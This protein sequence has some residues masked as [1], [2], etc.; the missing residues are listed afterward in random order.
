MKSNTIQHLVA[1]RA[2]LSPHKEALVEGEQRY[3]YEMFSNQINRIANFLV[4]QGVT[5][6]DRVGILART[7]AAYP[8]VMMAIVKIGAVVSPLS[9]NM[10][11]YELD[12]IIE[13][14][15]LKALLHHQEFS[16]VV[17]GAKAIDQLDFTVTLEREPKFNEQFN[18][19]SAKEPFI[20]YEVTEEDTALM[21]F[22][23]GTTG[24]AKGCMISHGGV[25]KYLESGRTEDLIHVEMH[26]LFVHPFFH[27]SSM[28]SMFHC[29]KS[30]V[31]MVC[32]EETEPARILDVIEK[33]DITLLLALPP[34]LTYLLEELEQNP[35]ENLP[36]KLALSG[37]T[38][39]PESLIRNLEKHGVTVAQGYGSTEAWVISAWA[40]QMGWDKV[41]SVGK[42]ISGVEV[43]VV[44][45][46][47]REAVAT[48][49]IGE[50]LV[51]SPYIFKGYWGNEAATQA[52]LHDGW[53][54]MGDAGK[55]D[56]DGFLYIDGRYKDVIVYGGDN[57]YPDQVEDV[58][59]GIDDVLETALVGM[60]DT[61]YGEVPYAYTVVREE[62]GITETEVKEYCKERLTA[63]KVP[64][65]V[66]VPSLPKN[67]VGK[68]MKKKVKE[69]ALAHA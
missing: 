19:F 31:T 55:L 20:N 12:H 44:N 63:Y 16:T 56:E 43:K 46:E 27:M 65:I 48:G 36:W 28:N 30:G 37:G 7:T 67:S 39:V 33:E 60:P 38:K 26:Y 58:I 8:T 10:T 34:A 17:E 53:L 62:C 13:S 41:N 23:S 49:E 42:P 47:T 40:P 11:S 69:L 61:L 18:K 9:E 21:M 15:K 54:S 66:F 64:E 3:T 2:M 1:E 14:G 35:R 50:V 51:K 32:S 25:R 22:T 24:N 52:V 57:I 45:P 4:S 6:G 5:K 29:I 68:I 59:L